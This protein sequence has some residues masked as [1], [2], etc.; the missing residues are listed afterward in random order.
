MN[1]CDVLHVIES[2]FQEISR[3]SVSL[4]WLDS[5]KVLSSILGKRY[6][7]LQLEE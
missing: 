4:P 2:S 6:L 3:F 1:L 5:E 7:S